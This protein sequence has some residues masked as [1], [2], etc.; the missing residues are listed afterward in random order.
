M[1]SEEQ[2]NDIYRA[3]H[4]SNKPSYDLIRTLAAQYGITVE[5][6][7]NIINDIYAKKGRRKYL[8]INK[9][10][11]VEVSIKITIVFGVSENYD[12]TNI[13]K[14]TKEYIQGTLDEAY[15]RAVQIE[16]ENIHVINYTIK[17]IL[18]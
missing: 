1:L 6:T 14:D 5:E 9:V 10:A 15:G 8:T 4:H 18:Q 13:L 2:R 11:E 3:F 7:V 17:D 16:D 12:D